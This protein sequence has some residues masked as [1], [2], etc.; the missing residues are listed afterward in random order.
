MT[1]DERHRPSK[2]RPSVVDRYFRIRFS[3]AKNFPEHP[4]YV[5]PGRET[6][7]L[8]PCVARRFSEGHCTSQVRGAEGERPEAGIC[9]WMFPRR[10]QKLWRRQTIP[11]PPHLASAH[12][13]PS[14]KFLALHAVLLFGVIATAT[15]AAGRLW[16]ASQSNFK[17]QL[18]IERRSRPIP[19]HLI[20][21]FLPNY[22]IAGEARNITTVLSSGRSVGSRARVSLLCIL[23]F[24]RKE[25][26]INNNKK[27]RSYSKRTAGKDH[28]QKSDIPRQASAS[29]S[30][31]TKPE[32]KCPP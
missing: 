3:G 18:T 14:C 27:G 19:S 22:P 15:G 23:A 20:N 17:R 16:A 12:I 25:G 8:T 5:F 28:A 26:K 7:F 2:L 13:S 10:R 6:F 11:A 29:A 32:P 4:P 30:T 31:I 21:L 24:S 9:S 1:S